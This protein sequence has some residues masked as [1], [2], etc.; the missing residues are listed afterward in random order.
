MSE[1]HST[2]AEAGDGSGRSADDAERPRDP[3]GGARTDETSEWELFCR[4]Q[5]GEALKHVGSVTAPTAEVADEMAGA[6]FD[7]PQTVWVCPADDVERF[8]ERRLADGAGGADS[9]TEVSDA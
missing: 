7:D 6:L 2:G 3:V 5:A 8:S 1:Q 4:E 9:G